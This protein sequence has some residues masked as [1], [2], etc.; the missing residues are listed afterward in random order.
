MYS[1]QNIGAHEE[2]RMDPKDERLVLMA[3]NVGKMEQATEELWS[4]K[5]E[6]NKAN[7]D[8]E[9]LRSRIESLERSNRHWSNSYDEIERKYNSLK[10]K[11]TKKKAVKK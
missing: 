9:A 6:L 5:N 8:R 11:T 4:L 7:A 2:Q 1:S 10:K 3:Y